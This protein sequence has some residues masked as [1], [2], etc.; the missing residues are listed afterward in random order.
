MVLVL[1]TSI[2]KVVGCANYDVMPMNSKA[3]QRQMPLYLKPEPEN[4]KDENAIAVY[5]QDNNQL[6]GYVEAK[7][8]SVLGPLIILLICVLNNTV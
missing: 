2:L 4:L 6:V 5:R 8:T 3:E 7:K 1:G